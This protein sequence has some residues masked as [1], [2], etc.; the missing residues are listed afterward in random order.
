MSNFPLAA[1]I[2]F[3]SLALAVVVATTVLALTIANSQ[4]GETNAFKARFTDASGLL[5]DDEVRIA[6]VIVG[7]ITDIQI[8]DQNLA[9]VTFTV[10]SGQP[11]P[12]SA[13]A[14]I[15]YKN[16]VGQRYL[17][18]TQGAGPT[19]ARLEPGATIPLERTQG[20]LNLTVLFN[21]FKPLFT[22][23][24]PEQINQLSFEI[25]QVLQGQGGTVRSLLA[26]TSSL[27]N[28]VADRDEV[29]G[30]V[31]NNLND[32][33][34][35]ANA[36]D[37]R[38]G[39]LVSSL[40]A[41]VSGL[42]EDREPIGEAIESIA[43]LTEVTAGF[44]AEARPALKDDIVALGD[45]A[46]NLNDNEETVDEFLRLLPRKLNTIGRA[47]SYAS[48][49]NFYLCGVEGGSVSFGNSQVI[50]LPPV[51]IPIGDPARCSADPDQDGITDVADLPST[52]LALDKVSFL[53]DMS[54]ARIDLPLVVGN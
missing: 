28:T 11:V 52:T 23:L 8:V 45:L 36:G 5:R 32:V 6:G 42:A 25:V 41:L 3:L 37:Q 26:N 47:G 16:L 44:I 40:Q 51:L 46:D 1:L 33:L 54:P 21:G 15:Y 17:Q 13:G 18:L 50:N 35:T 27:T 2:K 49:F 20:P 12:A 43:E 7:R 10:E 48:W 19:G 53:P 24:D 9:E 22:A 38:V 14:A 31:I 39:E 30:Q 4:G 34:A 29:V